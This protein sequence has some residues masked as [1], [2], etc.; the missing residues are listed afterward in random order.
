MLGGVYNNDWDFN[1]DNDLELRIDYFFDGIINFNN[2]KQVLIIDVVQDYIYSFNYVFYIE[3]LNIDVSV[4]NLV[5]GKMENLLWKDFFS[6]EILDKVI[7]KLNNVLD[8]NSFNM[9]VNIY[10]YKKFVIDGKYDYEE[11]DDSW[12]SYEDY[13]YFEEIDIDYI[14]EYDV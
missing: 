2:E 12:E 6:F 3:Y 8:G 9:V 7:K 11:E 1:L 5:N 4:G 14:D 13:N 10:F